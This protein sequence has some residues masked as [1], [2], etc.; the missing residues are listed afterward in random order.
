MFGNR[1]WIYIYHCRL[2]NENS[3]Q[4]LPLKK[5]NFGAWFRRF[6]H[7]LS[8]GMETKFGQLLDFIF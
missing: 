1:Q 6:E 7:P 2:P 8:W 5:L 4:K 3:S